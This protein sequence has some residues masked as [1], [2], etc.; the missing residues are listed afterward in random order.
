MFIIKGEGYSR[1]H[2]I[3]QK[4]MIMNIFGPFTILKCIYKSVILIVFI[5]YLLFLIYSFKLFSPKH[6]QPQN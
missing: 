2:F 4:N 5:L 3:G 1:E 6:T